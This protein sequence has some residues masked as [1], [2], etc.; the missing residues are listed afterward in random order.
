MVS[1]VLQ[2][3]GKEPLFFLY[4][5]LYTYFVQCIDYNNGELPHLL[6]PVIQNP[7][8]QIMLLYLDVDMR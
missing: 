8:S 4:G 2:H 3:V 7:V 5:S 1:Y 6:I